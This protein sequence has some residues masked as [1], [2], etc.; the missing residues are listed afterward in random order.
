MTKLVIKLPM[1]P[2]I[3][4]VKALPIIR[5]KI[6]LAGGDNIFGL[7]IGKKG[8]LEA[9]AIVAIDPSSQGSGSFKYIK[10]IEPN[11]PMKRES[12]TCKRGIKFL[13]NKVP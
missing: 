11:S 1:Y 9:T 7:F 2:S 13:N 6:V 8:S 12:S 4:G 5:P 3:A 10:S